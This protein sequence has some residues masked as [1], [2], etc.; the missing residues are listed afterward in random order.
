[1][2]RG[3]RGHREEAGELRRRGRQAGRNVVTEPDQQPA[4]R[5]ALLKLSGEALMGDQG[6]G[7]SIEVIDALAA[8]IA[9]TMEL[10]VE[11]AVVVGGGNIF[12]GVSDSAQ[13][14]DRS[15]ADYMGMLATIMNAVALQDA[16]E[17]RGVATRV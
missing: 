3:R 11:L 9:A 6:F 1:P 10:G 17:R 16:T 8:E 13:G 5:R 14:M 7:I 15:S 2:L 4:Y 12:R